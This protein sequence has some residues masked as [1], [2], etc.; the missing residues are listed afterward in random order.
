[1]LSICFKKKKKL[2]Q[3]TQFWTTMYRMFLWKWE[4]HEQLSMALKA[5]SFLISQILRRWEYSVMNCS[6]CRSKLCG[7]LGWL[8]RGLLCLYCEQRPGSS[9]LE[10][11]V[12][13]WELPPKGRNKQYRKC[14]PGVCWCTVL[15][16]RR[17]TYRS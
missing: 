7:G 8:P 5:T 15:C 3:I 6:V 4:S 17:D 16:G 14:A 9:L 2:M 1:M 10:C 12:K 13:L 11:N